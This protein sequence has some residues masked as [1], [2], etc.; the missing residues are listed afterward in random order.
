MSRQRDDDLSEVVKIVSRSLRL[1]Q[2]VC[3]T[4]KTD[5]PYDEDVWSLIGSLPQLEQLLFWCTPI[6]VKALCH[7]VLIPQPKTSTHATT[8]MAFRALITME[9]FYWNFDKDESDMLGILEALY[10]CM[11]Q[12]NRANV[13]LKKLRFSSCYG[14]EDYIA[15][16]KQVVYEI[17]WNRFQGP[18]VNDKEEFVEFRDEGSVNPDSADEAAEREDQGVVEL[19]DHV[20]SAMTHS[21]D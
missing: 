13:P 9:F 4:V 2:L 10:H 8:H 16:L 6:L 12:R 5:A 3:I 21:S 17:S 20:E 15:P 11:K 7:Q 18:G 14:F 19:Q 1:D